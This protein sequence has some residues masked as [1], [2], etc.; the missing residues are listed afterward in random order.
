MSSARSNAASVFSGA[1]DEAPRCAM[2]MKP[3]EGMRGGRSAR[4]GSKLDAGN[5]GG[6]EADGHPRGD[7][8]AS[9]RSIFHTLR[10]EHVE[11]RARGIA[12]PHERHEVAV[13]LG[14]GAVALRERRLAVEI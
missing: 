13:V 8:G 5:P 3:A 6:V 2:T 12:V 1:Y 7:D 4:V 11:L 10:I 14:A 9:N